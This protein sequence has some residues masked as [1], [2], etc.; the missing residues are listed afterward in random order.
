[1]AARFLRLGIASAAILIFVVCV[2]ASSLAGPAASKP[3]AAPGKTGDMWDVT[4]QVAIEGMPM[5]MPAQTHQV[6]APK[7]WNEPPGAQSAGENCQVSDVHSTGSKTTWK[8]KCTSPDM[9]GEGEVTRTSPDAYTGSIKM[10]S[11][12]GNITIK[13]SGKRTGECDYKDTSMTPAQSAAAS[14]KLDADLAK[15]QA[16]GCKGL[17]EGLQLQMLK[18]HGSGCDD[19]A[20]Q[21]M[22]CKKAFSPE[23]TKELMGRP[24]TMTGYT[25]KE[26]L[27]FCSGSPGKAAYCGQFNTPA[28]YVQ[29]ASAGTGQGTPQATLMA[30]CGLSAAQVDEDRQKICK[31]ITGLSEPIFLAKYCPAE[32]KQLAEKE[33]AGR[34]FTG[35]APTPYKE[36]CSTYAMQQASQP[37]P[38]AEAEDTKG[39]KTKKFLKGLWPH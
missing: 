35:A 13:L 25:L 5:R 22:F 33:C 32:A 6:C 10:A 26:S 16:E 39:K 27:D 3:A 24:D 14:Q 4:S 31:T 21:E 9:T 11:S 8:M 18:M 29:F 7:S 28:G 1:M 15:M 30:F 19:P 36:F 23:G 34:S 37:A 2:A 20:T 17:A 12:D 38:A